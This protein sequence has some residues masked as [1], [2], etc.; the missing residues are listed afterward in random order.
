[1]LS[2]PSG[3][4]WP[5]GAQLQIILTISGLLGAD[6][7]LD[8]AIGRAGLQEHDVGRRRA[9]TGQTVRFRGISFP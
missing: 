6:T 5:Q 1:M 7:D 8:Q 9:H 3:G 4:T 2:R